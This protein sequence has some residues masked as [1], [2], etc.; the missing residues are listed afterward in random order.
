M[1]SVRITKNTLSKNLQ[2]L[3][4][5]DLTNEWGRICA[6]EL[7]RISRD[8]VPFGR[9][10]KGD[11]KYRPGRLSQS[12][13]FRPEGKS[14]IT[15]YDTKYAMY[16]HEGMRRDGSRIVRNWSN[17]RKS[18][19]LENP[20]KENISTWNKVANQVLMQELKKKL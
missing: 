6:G 16:Q 11:K 15:G 1:S 12:G 9:K 8:I 17:G 14:W 7:L 3:Q 20:L 13:F 19:Y 5:M 18:K 2:K 4:N 10:R